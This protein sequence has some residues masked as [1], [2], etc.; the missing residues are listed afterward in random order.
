MFVVPKK[1]VEIAV[2]TRCALFFDYL[3]LIVSGN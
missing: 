3:P 2:L 1:L